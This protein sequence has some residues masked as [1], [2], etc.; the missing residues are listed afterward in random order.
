MMLLVSAGMP[1]LA[2]EFAGRFAREN[3]GYRPTPEQAAKVRQHQ[4]I[5]M[6]RN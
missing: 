4:H 3:A 5:M 6:G 2:A 1:K